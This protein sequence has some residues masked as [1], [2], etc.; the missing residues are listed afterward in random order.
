MKFYVFFLALDRINAARMAFAAITK[1]EQQQKQQKQQ[2]Q[3][4]N[5]S[6]MIG[7]SKVLK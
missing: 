7:L 2:K 5:L 1:L 4:N 6:W 3:Q